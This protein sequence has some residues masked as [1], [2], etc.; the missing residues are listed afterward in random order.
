MRLIG[1]IRPTK[2]TKLESAGHDR[3]SAYDGLIALV[4]TGHELVQAHFDK[5]A[6]VTTGRG[7]IRPD[8]IEQLE[9]EGATYPEAQAALQA[10]VPAGY[11][12]LSSY[13]DN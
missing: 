7:L 9:A 8:R 13:I 6:G 12:L 4:P 3:G 11:Q 2:T 10:L 5:A 1:S